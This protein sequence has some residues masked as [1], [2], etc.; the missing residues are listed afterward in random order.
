VLLMLAVTGIQSSVRL[1]RGGSPIAAFGSRTGTLMR[2]IYELRRDLNVPIVVTLH[3]FGR[4]STL[5]PI[6]GR[7]LYRRVVSNCD[8]VI[9]HTGIA[10]NAVVNRF[11]VPEDKVTVIPHP[12]ARPPVVTASCDDLRRRFGLDDA[13]VMLAFGFI[14]VDKGLDD[15]V[16]ALG[17]LRASGCAQLED[18][19]LVVAGAVRPRQGLFRAF[20]LRDRLHLHRVMR[21]ARRNGVGER[22][23]L[24][25]YVPAGEVSAWFS[26]ADVVVLPYRRIEQSGVASMARSFPAPVLASTAGGLTEQFAGSSWSFPPRA[27]DELA[28]TIEQFLA[29]TPGERMPSRTDECADDPATVVARTLELYR[30][31]IA[32]CENCRS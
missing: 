9:V 1:W 22:L 17:I 7:A 18:Y 28:R 32:A 12:S 30:M 26:L 27:P 4:E 19:V 31:A 10:M 25:G 6:A 2:R 20:E 11:G 8:Q 13:R 23:V 29:A 15:L 5:L 3:E 16:R 14:H 21:L 24:T